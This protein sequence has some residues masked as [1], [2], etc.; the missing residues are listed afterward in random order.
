MP[1]GRRWAP[2]VGRQLPHVSP[3]LPGCPPTPHIARGT[4]RI[5][6]VSG[7]DVRFR[8]QF[9]EQGGV[10]VGYSALGEEA[11]L[12]VVAGDHPVVGEDRV[13][14]VVERHLLEVAELTP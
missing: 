1:P 7:L 13:P 11:N 8:V 10:V 4:A 9:P 14:G 12:G 5:A 2:S 3:D 6:P